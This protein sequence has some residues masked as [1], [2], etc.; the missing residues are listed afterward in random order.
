MALTIDAGMCPPNNDTSLVAYYPFDE[1][2]GSIAHD[3]SGHG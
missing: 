3:C 2:S 1:G